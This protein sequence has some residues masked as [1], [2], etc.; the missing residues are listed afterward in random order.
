MVGDILTEQ[1]VQGTHGHL[2]QGIE[3]GFPVNGDREDVL[4]EVQM[5]IVE[6]HGQANG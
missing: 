6:G 3:G 4:L 5:Q 2:V 1:S